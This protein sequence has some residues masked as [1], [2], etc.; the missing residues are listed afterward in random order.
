MSGATR[1]GT[2]MIT[3]PGATNRTEIV[4]GITEDRCWTR[5]GLPLLVRLSSPLPARPAISAA[6]PLALFAQL[7]FA[8]ARFAQVAANIS[9]DSAL[10]GLP[11]PAA[12]P[13]TAF[14][15]PVLHFTGSP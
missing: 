3:G 8:K 6:V 9:R 5:N 2:G 7:V 15:E 12:V 13:L 10:T 1:T 11:V 14:A 4:G